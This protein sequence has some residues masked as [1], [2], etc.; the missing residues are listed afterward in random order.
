MQKTALAILLV[1]LAAFP[2]ILLAGEEKPLPQELP[3]FGPDLPLPVP[4]IKA[5]KLPEGLTVWLVQ[6]A[7]FPMVTAILTVRGGTASDPRGM[8]GI[9]DT[10]ADTLNEGTATRT[11][12][13]IAE[14]LQEVGGTLSTNATSDAI[15]LT[16]AGL[17]SGSTRLLTILADVARNAS[18]PVQEVELAKTN[19]LQGLE[20]QAST[21]EFLAQKAFAA[22]V[23]DDHPYRTVAATP[24]TI[25]AITPDLLKRE[26]LRRFRPERALLV[27]V[28]DLDAAATG[29]TIGKV[30]AG[31]KGQGEALAP[32]PPSPGAKARQLLV[33]SRPGSVQSLI[34]LGRPTVPATD[35]EYF[36]L[37][38]ANTVFGGA[39]GSRLTRNIR[40]DKGYSYGAS[41]SVQTREE[42]GLLQVRA[43]VRNEVTA[44]T[45]LEMFYE[46]DR[47][48][49]TVPTA[50]EVAK[51]KRY[52]G[53]LYLLRNQIQGAVA[54]TLATNWV[55]GLP[56]GALGD[57]VPKVN[58][59]TVE[60]IRQAG[61]DFYT[62]RSQTIVVVGDE[63]KVQSELSQFGST[64]TIQP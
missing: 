12:K 18:F 32:T 41:S 25:A 16:V 23:Y 37:L 58:A 35:P 64:K 5:S 1:A 11:S 9:S 24:E 56:P 26:F 29:K 63:A 52:Q 48:G 2:V 62:S 51:A 14:D 33:V 57:F 15:Q 59:V 42:G 8:E 50:E 36:P 13:Q 39:F 44:A 10:L 17:A 19:A 53:G 54:G 31:W 38:V 28:G 40:E 46:L 27:V 49:A 34:M 3:P 6:R 30:F 20:V 21:P 45:L 4:T 47:M 55:D 7:G 43:D 60:Q 61:R 22:A